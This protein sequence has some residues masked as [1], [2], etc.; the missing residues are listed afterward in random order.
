MTPRRRSWQAGRLRL[1]CAALALCAGGCSAPTAVVV[2]LTVR[3][4]DPAPTTLTA[5]VF[6]RTRALASARAVPHPHFPGTFAVTGLPDSEQILRFAFDGMPR[7]VAGVSLTVQPHVTTHVAVEL[8]AATLDSDADGVPDSVDDCVLVANPDQ[9]DG[10]GDGVGDACGTGDLGAP[11][12]ASSDQAVASACPIAG[13]TL[14]EG[15]E[16]GLPALWQPGLASGVA[17]SIQV[18]SVHAF[19]GRNALHLHTDPVAGGTHTQLALVQSATFPMSTLYVRTYVYLPSATEP[20]G[21][22]LLQLYQSDAEPYGYAFLTLDSGGR[23]GFIDTIS[24][25]S[26]T[27]SSGTTLPSDRWFCL[28]WRFTEAPSDLG[29]ASGLVDVWVDGAAVPELHA[30]MNVAAWPPFHQFGLVDDNNAGPR[31]SGSDVWYDELAIGPSRIGC[32]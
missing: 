4:G 17:S 27:L 18:D 7:A 6:D 8:S 20:L 30:T 5:S 23:V 13:A 10:D 2:E 9:A 28:E 29:G 16:H 25:P 26:Q 21:S 3:A 1:V 31:P 19:A 22:S 14:C 32:E 12:L 11:D 15:W 24:V